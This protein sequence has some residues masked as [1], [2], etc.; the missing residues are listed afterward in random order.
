V[1]FDWLNRFQHDIEKEPS[2]AEKVLAAYALG[3]KAKGSIVG[4]VIEPAPDCCTQ[5]RQLPP[6]QLYPPHEAPLLPLAG[7]P[8]GRRCGCIYRPVMS[9]QRAG[10]KTDSSR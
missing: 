8:L 7:C 6:T 10:E 1:A 3:M 5:V 4:V 9:Y 2:Y